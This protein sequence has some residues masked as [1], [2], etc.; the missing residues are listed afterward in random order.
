MTE[1]KL[2]ENSHIQNLY[3]AT[4]WPAMDNSAFI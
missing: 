2:V 4:K 1:L 3:S